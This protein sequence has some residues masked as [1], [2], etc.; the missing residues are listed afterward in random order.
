VKQPGTPLASWQRGQVEQDT[1]PTAARLAAARLLQLTLPGTG[2]SVSVARRCAGM[3]TARLGH[4]RIASADVE[5]LVAE[6][7]ANA[8]EHTASGAGG[9]FTVE[10]LLE[11]R[12]SRP[13]LTVAVHDQGSGSEPVVRPVGV[14][15]GEGISGRGLL[16]VADLA[17]R[18]GSGESAARGGRVVWA[19]LVSGAAG[20]AGDN[21]VSGVAGAAGDGRV[22]DLTGAEAGAR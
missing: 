10:L 12:G 2:L 6:L 11:V 8:V 16:L 1:E 3:L 7:A 21:L 9:R 14:E 17:S 19:E 13:V 4:L 20:T 22:P 18:W 15:G 5:L